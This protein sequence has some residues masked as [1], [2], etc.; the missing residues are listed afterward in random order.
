V[1]QAALDHEGLIG[2][3]HRDAAAQQDLQSFDDLGG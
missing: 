2:A 3:R 1:W